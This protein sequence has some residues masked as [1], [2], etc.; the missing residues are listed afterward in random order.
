[1]NTLSTLYS[2]FY[3]EFSLR[4]SLLFWIGALCL[5][6]M[7]VLLANFSEYADDFYHKF[8]AAN[9]IWW[10]LLITP[11][12][13]VAI[14]F[15]SRFFYYINGSGIPQVIAALLSKDEARS[16]KLLAGI[17]IIGKFL[18]T[19]AA[20]AVGASVG[21]EGPTVQIGA[22][23]LFFIWNI[24]HFNKKRD[25]KYARAFILAGGAAGI[26]AAFNTPIAGIIFAIEELARSFESHVSATILT[27][28]IISGLVAQVF[29][30]NY[31]YFGYAHITTFGDYDWAAIFV[32]AIIGGLAGGLFSKLLTKGVFGL[33]KYY[34]N[35]P[36]IVALVCGLIV[37]GLGIYT[38]GKTFGSGYSEARAIMQSSEYTGAGQF[39][40]TK[41]CATL[42]TYLS[43]VPGG[44]FAP[45]LAAG[46]GFGDF[47][48]GIFTVFNYKVMI[49]LTMTAFFS[50]V[51]R[52]PIT[53]FVIVSEMLSAHNMV[54]PVMATSLLATGFSK[55]FSPQPLYDILAEKYMESR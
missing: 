48:A 41:M 2:K 37:A 9:S 23:I 5:G 20:V 35:N 47:L 38:N 24:G 12:G 29:L 32:A 42:F 4:H 54:F 44:L 49:V 17:D 36:Y 52:S 53:C 46:I 21:R 15:F 27:A 43:G 55:L 51:L 28:I 3:K 33:G 22:A 25:Q 18:M 8:L 10:A 40:I 6:G 13:F 16:R 19:I 7:S 14:V 45:T 50:G 11:L 34:Q 39:A 30:G 31:T 26:S 1:M